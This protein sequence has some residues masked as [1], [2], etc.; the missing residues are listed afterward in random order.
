MDKAEGLRAKRR[1][2]LAELDPLGQSIFLEMFGDPVLNGQSWPLKSIEQIAASSK[3][4]IVDGPFGS[5]I[6]PED[7]KNTGVPVVRITNITKAGYF[8]PKNL[9]FI[10]ESKFESLRRSS[11]NPGDVLVSRVGTLGNSCI[12]PDGI[13]DALLSTTGVCKITVNQERMLPV[14]LHHSLRM[15]S[16]QDQIQKSASTSVQKYFNLTALKRWKIIVPPLNLQK[17]FAYR[18][19]AVEKLKTVHCS[20]LAE[21]DALFSSLQH[22]AYNGDL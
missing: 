15:A 1:A 19:S 4:A 21:L 8:L 5:S 17:E 20:A 22:R 14:F 12:F 9:L 2:A 10:A 11:V 13:G 7:Y 18:I 6:K 16:F 3:H